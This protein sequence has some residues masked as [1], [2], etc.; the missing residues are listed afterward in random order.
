MPMFK[1]IKEIAILTGLSIITAFVVNYFSPKGIA[2]KGQWDTDQGVIS[3]QSKNSIV[4]NELEIKTPATAK[5]MF[6]KGIY[7]FVDA[8][9]SEDYEE[10]HIKGAVSLPVGEFYDRIDTFVNNYPS[11]YSIITYCS[12]RECDDSHELVQYLIDEGYAD[13]KA[14][15]DGYP[16][17]EK[18]GFPIE[19]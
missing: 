8:R 16:A 18:E 4:D 2:L 17:W 14:F 15:I 11:S 10:G 5:E 19:K 12:G 13:V 1:I 7:I 9:S 3:A 6:E